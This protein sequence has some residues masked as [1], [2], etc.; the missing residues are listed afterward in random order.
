MRKLITIFFAFI[1][2]QSCVFIRMDDSV[3]LGSNYRFIQDTPQTIIY[4]SSD[5]Y[6]GSGIEII[7]PLV[8]SYGFNKRYILA[9]TQEVDEMTG[10]KEGKPIRYWIIDKQLKGDSVEPMDS[11]SFYKT[12]EVKNIKVRLTPWLR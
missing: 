11:I 7:P 8:L 2:I 3:D 5:D 1:L 4:H 10:R 12:L 6:E 9:K